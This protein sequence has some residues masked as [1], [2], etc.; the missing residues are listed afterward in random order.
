MRRGVW[1]VLVIMATLLPWRVALACAHDAESMQQRCC[2]IDVMAP[3]PH[4]SSGVG[5]CCK[6]VVAL[7]AQVKDAEADSLPTFVKNGESLLEV[8]TVDAGVDGIFTDQP[9]IVLQWRNQRLQQAG[10]GNPFRLLNTA[11]PGAAQQDP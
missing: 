7:R 2:C 9:D 8:L 11:S 1:A 10:R 6:Q 3:C 5:K 4:V